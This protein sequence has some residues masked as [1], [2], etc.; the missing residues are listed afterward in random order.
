MGFTL[1]VP[2][3]KS[4]SFSK[5]KSIFAIYVW[6]HILLWP[7][8]TSRSDRHCTVR[9]FAKGEFYYKRLG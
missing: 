9:F 4:M 1:T 7:T 5:A 8:F 3:E 6:G 2:Y